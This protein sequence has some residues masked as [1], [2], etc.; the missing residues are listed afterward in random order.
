MTSSAHSRAPTLETERLRLRE[1]GPHDLDAATAFWARPDVFRHIDGKPRP[2]E[3]VWRRILANAGSWALLGFGS[4]AVETRAD[5]S[6]V[7]SFGFLS[8]ERDMV[9]PFGSGEIETGWS[10]APDAQGKGYA[11]EALS[12]ALAWADAALPRRRLVCII[13]EANAASLRLA[14]KV[15]FRERRRAIYKAA[16]VIQFERELRA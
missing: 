11:L 4:W 12:A 8:A 1:Q 10:L 13:D 15:G 7:G 6:Y 14:A 3:E 16:E 5:A 9:P 2:R